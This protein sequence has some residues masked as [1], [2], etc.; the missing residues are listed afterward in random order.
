MPADLQG[1]FAKEPNHARSDVVEGFPVTKEGSAARFFYCSKA[2][3]KDRNEG[4][5]STRT[6]KYT[7][8]KS[9]IGELSCSDVSTA[10]VESLRRVMSESTVTWSIGESGESITGLCPSDYLSTTLTEISKITG[11]KILSLLPPCTT[12]GYTQDVNCE[13]V[14]GGNHADGVESSSKYLQTTMSESQAESALGVKAVVSEMLLTISDGE[15]WKPMT[16]FHTTVK[17]TALMR[18]LCRLITPPGGTIIDP[19]MGSGSTGKSA[20]LE[21]FDFIGIELDAD[22]FEIAEKRIAIAQDPS[23]TIADVSDDGTINLFSREQHEKI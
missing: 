16:N 8:D 6:V 2:S 10:L 5:D 18:Y 22:Y 4:L 17:P 7:V 21:G 15:N 23:H 14:S 20:K 13:M 1:L 3:K 9:L 12:S 19:Y 11:S